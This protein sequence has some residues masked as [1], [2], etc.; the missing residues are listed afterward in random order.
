MALLTGHMTKLEAVNEMLFTIGERPV[1]SLASGL[2]EASQAEDI[3]DRESRRI[4]MKGWHG[5]TLFNF[6]I[7]P[8]AGNQFALPDN[9][10]KVDTVNPQYRRSA[11]TPAP[12]KYVNVSMRRSAD[13]TKWLLWDND[14]GLETMTDVTQLTVEMVL[15]LEFADLTPALQIYIWTSA[16]RRFQQGTVGSAAL[17]AFTVEDVVDAMADAVNEDLEN[18]DANIISDNQHVASI[19]RR[20]SAS[21]G[22]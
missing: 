20:R 12:S 15:F 7:T 1:N 11:S 16:A 2:S 21:S 5:N 3:L 18:S 10:L 14:N 4:Q 17:D 8:N 9:V 19:A 13:D 6:Q 22:T